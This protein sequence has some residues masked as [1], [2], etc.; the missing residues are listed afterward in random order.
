[1]TQ[2]QAENGSGA[3]DTDGK[4][5]RKPYHP[6]TVILSEISGVTGIPIHKTYPSVPVDYTT[7]GNSNV[8]PPPS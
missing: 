1:M 6:P 4:A 5:G 2:D 7:G 8:G 3:L